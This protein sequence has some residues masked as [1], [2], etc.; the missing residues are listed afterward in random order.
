M[1]PPTKS[2]AFYLALLLASAFIALSCILLIKPSASTRAAQ[3]PK[4]ALSD[5]VPPS[6]LSS[7]SDAEVAAL[8]S[9]SEIGSL[10]P[11]ESRLFGAT[12][13]PRA[14][15]ED[16]VPEE[17]AASFFP[18]PSEILAMLARDRDVD[19]YLENAAEK[20]PA[21]AY[22]QAVADMVPSMK[23]LRG[24][25]EMFFAGAYGALREMGRLK[26]PAQAYAD[27]TLYKSGVTLPR[28]SSKPRTQDYDYSHTFALDIFL[29]N[30]GT[31]P[32]SSLEKGPIVFSLTD[33]IV[34]ATNSSWMGGEDLTSYRSGGITPK[35]GNGVI[36]Y[37][38]AKRK[39][40]LYFHLFDVLVAP[41][42]A[43][44]KG[45]PLGHGGNT[46]TNARKPGHG[47]HLHLE[48]YDA[49]ASRFLKNFEIAD[50]VF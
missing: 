14:V 26:V 47:E 8:L 41:G 36:L 29:D 48:I 40:Y 42:E 16:I 24:N 15:L 35:A 31:L 33:A 23:P 7:L 27:S 21:G 12:I 2:R 20:G 28:L 44:P 39:Y 11:E 46:G 32:F 10:E 4:A 5:G 3:N 9:K 43:I 50:I 18:S 22:Y 6:N 37:S 13:V 30:V 17:Y 19:D 38:P 1:M 25:Y 34:I 45:Y 49:A